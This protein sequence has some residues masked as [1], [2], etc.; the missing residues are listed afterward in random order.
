MTSKGLKCMIYEANQQ[1][2]EGDG[3]L[4]LLCF[5]AFTEQKGEKKTKNQLLFFSSL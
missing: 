1:E 5:P 3:M 2:K 4:L